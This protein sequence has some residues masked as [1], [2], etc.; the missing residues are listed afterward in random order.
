MTPEA[1][2]YLQELFIKDSSKFME[3]CGEYRKGITHAILNQAALTAEEINKLVSLAK[4]GSPTITIEYREGYVRTPI[5][6]PGFKEN[7]N[8]GNH[9]KDL[10]NYYFIKEKQKEDTK[11]ISYSEFCPMGDI[12]KKRLEQRLREEEE[13]E[14]YEMCNEILKYAKSRGID[15][16][17]KNKPIG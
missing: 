13:I 3:L 12:S 7:E 10:K 16:N 14:N 5:P 1:K 9:I 4:N 8:F 11:T 15:L 6:S 17:I 2:I